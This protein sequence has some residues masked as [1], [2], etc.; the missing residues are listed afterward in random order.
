M[1]LTPVQWGLLAGS[2]TLAAAL[3]FSFRRV[4]RASRQPAVPVGSVAAPEGAGQ[5]TTVLSGFDYAQTSAGKPKFQIHAD[6]TVGF[7][8]G[9]GLPSTWYGLETVALTLFSDEGAPFKVRSDRADYDPRTRATHLKGKVVMTDGSGMDLRTA[10]VDYDPARETLQAPGPVEIVRGGIRGHAASAQYDAR[11]K[12]LVLAGPVTAEGLGLG[13]AAPAAAPPFSSLRADRGTYRRTLGEIELD[14]HVE[15][16]RGTD[17][18]SSD[19]LLM[20]VTSANRIDRASAEGSVEGS[21]AGAPGE[22]PRLFSAQTARLEF[23][24]AGELQSLR[25]EG[26]PARIESAPGAVGSV[27]QRIDARDVSL[28]YAAGRL[29]AAKAQ[30]DARMER[31]SRDPKGAAVPET[32][33]AD[34]ADASFANDGT[35][36]SARFEGNVVGTTPDAVAHAP[37]ARYTASENRMTFLGAGDRD[38]EVSAPRGKVIARRIDMISAASRLTASDSA[39]AFLKPSSGNGSLPGFLSSSKKPTRAKAARIEFDDAAKTAT[40]TGAAAI[41]QEDDALFGDTIRLFD[42]DRSATADG[43]VRAVSRSAA[44][45]DGKAQPPTTVTADTMRYGDAARTA[46]FA[47][48]VVAARGFQT[49]DGDSAECRFNSRDQLDRTVLSGRVAFSDS[50]TGRRGTGDRAEDDPLAGVTTLYGDPAVAHDGLGNR[51]AAA[52]LTFRKDSGTVDAKAKDGQK[53][54]SIY[55]TKGSAPGRTRGRMN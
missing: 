24:P 51:V 12:E 54:E 35:V 23:G 15:G 43:N 5:P 32:I 47:G 34:S 14:G 9:A 42:R 41:W 55:Q 1:K 48:R 36:G 10:A 6:R 18:F 52:V 44:S 31:I 22:I 17:R 7:A 50:A 19:A 20:H 45:A 28:E 38:A 21:V 37:S 27:S 26:S 4:P 39:R 46:R 30:G 25:L 29:R 16:T 53:I 33:R 49:A 13:A 8:Q 11:T 2:S 40:L 3:L